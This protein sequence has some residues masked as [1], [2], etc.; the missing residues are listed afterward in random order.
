MRRL[1]N[2]RATLDQA[3]SGWPIFDLCYFHTCAYSARVATAAGLGAKA[4]AICYADLVEV[5]G[6]LE[7][8]GAID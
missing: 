4:A 7:V 8:S 5:S 1:A 6:I 2:A 3:I